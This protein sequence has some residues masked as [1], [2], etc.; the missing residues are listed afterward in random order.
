MRE[1][2]GGDIKLQKELLLM[3]I[4]V[5]DAQEGLYWAREYRIPKQEWPWMIV[6]AEENE[7]EEEAEEEGAQGNVL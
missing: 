2:I 1:A 4:N 6:H 5:N 7:G 3:L